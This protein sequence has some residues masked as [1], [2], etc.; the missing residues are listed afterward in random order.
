LKATQAVMFLREF[1]NL[2]KADAAPGGPCFPVTDILTRSMSR[3][4]RDR[5]FH[6]QDAIALEWLLSVNRLSGSAKKE[7][8]ELV[9]ALAQRF[10]KSILYLNN[11][12]QTRIAG[13]LKSAVKLAGAMLDDVAQDRDR[14]SA[15]AGS[16]TKPASLLKQQHFLGST[17]SFRLL[18]LARSNIA[19]LEEGTPRILY[20]VHLYNM[21]RTVAGLEVVWD[22]LELLIKQLGVKKLFGRDTLPTTWSEIYQALECVR[23]D[24]AAKA[25]LRPSELMFI[26]DEYTLDPSAHNLRRLQAYIIR[27]KFEPT[28]GQSEMSKDLKQ[29]L[30]PDPSGA[31][32]YVIW[33][34]NEGLS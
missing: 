26:L 11:S 24:R 32:T 12:D 16:T 34:E 27:N 9:G 3:G 4:L 18:L 14:R 15:P 23:R 21:A 2:G 1:G 25:Y 29:S 10:R 17:L 7:P 8:Y 33:K 30:A 22:E 6:A 13:G 28:P 5:R 31:L 20:T 19:K